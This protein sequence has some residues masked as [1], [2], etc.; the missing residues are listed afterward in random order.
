MVK[1]PITEGDNTALALLYGFP[2]DFRLL[3]IPLNEVFNLGAS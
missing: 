2:V 1:I 3:N